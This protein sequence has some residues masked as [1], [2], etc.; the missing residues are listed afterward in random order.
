M[1]AALWAEG[2]CAPR[3]VV[4]LAPAGRRGGQ[5]CC[6]ERHVESL[7][8][9]TSSTP[10][11]KL[12]QIKRQKRRM[13]DDMFKEITNASG[14]ANT[15]LR[16]WRISLS[17]KLDTDMDSRRASQVPKYTTQE[18]MLRILKDQSDTLRHLVELQEKQLEARFPLQSLQNGL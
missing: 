11:E 6:S 10:P 4:C 14:T 9:S 15:E 3:A 2:L 12:S 1:G 13:H 18:E 17:E 8:F 16:A 7:A 5:T